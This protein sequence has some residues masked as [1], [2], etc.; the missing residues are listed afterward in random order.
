[1]RAHE[2]HGWYVKP[3][4]AANLAGTSRPSALAVFRLMNAC[5]RA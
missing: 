2:Q 1:V 5:G 4:T 3:P